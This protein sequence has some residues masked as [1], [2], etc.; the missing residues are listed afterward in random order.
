MGPASVDEDQSLSKTTHSSLSA[1]HTQKQSSASAANES[2]ERDTHRT[3]DYVTLLTLNDPSKA[4]DRLMCIHELKRYSPNMLTPAR[5]TGAFHP[6]PDEV[7]I[8]FQEMED[9]TAE[10][11]QIALYKFQRAKVVYVMCHAGKYFR[12]LKYRRKKERK[13]NGKKLFGRVTAPWR[14]EVNT[15]MNEEQTDFS[16]AFKR[17]W[18]IMKNAVI[19]DLD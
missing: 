16:I 6:R 12:V 1:A 18:T 15:I 14:S 2:R 3:P 10:Q 17:W 4:H 9:Q 11:A 5:T 13:R 7:H 8:I 19:E